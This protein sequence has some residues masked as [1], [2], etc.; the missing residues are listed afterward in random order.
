MSEINFFPIKWSIEPNWT[1]V[2]CVGRCLSNGRKITVTIPN[3]PYLT[4]Q[5]DLDLDLNLICKYEK[6]GNLARAYFPN[7]ISL[8]RFSRYFNGEIL[9]N[10]SALK[11]FFSWK[12]IEP[13]KCQ[14]ISNIQTSPIYH[15]DLDFLTSEIKSSNSNIHPLLIGFVYNFSGL[16]Y[17]TLVLQDTVKHHEFHHEKELE[18]TLL[19]YSL[20]QIIYFGNINYSQNISILDWNDLSFIYPVP[21]PKSSY[22][23]YEV[24]FRDEFPRR[25]LEFSNFWKQ[26]LTEFFLNGLSSEIYS[27][28]KV[29]NPTQKI[30]E[31]KSKNGL[32]KNVYGIQITKLLD[33]TNPIESYFINSGYEHLLIKYGVVSVNGYIWANSNLCFIC[34]SVPEAEK[35]LIL[36]LSELDQI[37]VDS[38]ENIY[39]NGI[40]N[41]S[42]PSFNLFDKY[43]IK[44]IQKELHPEI[45]LTSPNVDYEDF[46]ITTVL[47][48]NSDKKELVKQAQELGLLPVNYIKKVYYIQTTL[49]PLLL[50]IFNKNPNKYLDKIDINYYTENIFKY[51]KKIKS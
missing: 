36:V 51:L 8:E 21:T 43:L 41:I 49:G 6:I 24:F 14:I 31:T 13:G 30:T 48:P 32:Y 20:D 35:Y 15:S 17:L 10:V 28:I 47:T 50:E 5:E 16:H 39:R 38:N 37:L 26:D 4:F 40:G 2:F 22:E 9:D 29:M 33:I 23:M 42:N 46:I 11:K 7:K 19:D 44:I 1:Y 45:E 25:L 27:L 12:H 18:D 3:L 34:D